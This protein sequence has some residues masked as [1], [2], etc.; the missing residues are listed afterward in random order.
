LRAWAKGLLCLEAAVGLL[1][2]HEHWLRRED[3]A[4]AA[5]GFQ[6]CVFTGRALVSLDFV[7]AACAVE[8][9][10]LPCSSSERQMLLIAASIA[11]GVP[12]DL[13][14]ALTGLDETNT[15]RAVCAVVHVAGHDVVET[16]R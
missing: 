2:E 3:F 13:R 8:S 5:F 7:E 14:E 6:W 16:I 4:H 12:V 11:E 1:I 10:V 9:G 15:I